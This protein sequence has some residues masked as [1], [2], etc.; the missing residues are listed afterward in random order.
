MRRS[1]LLGA[2][3][4]TLLLALMM[5]GAWRSFFT[6][7]TV[8]MEESLRPPV[9][10]TLTLWVTGQDSGDRRLLST[11]LSLYEKSRPGLRIYLRAADASELYADSAVLPD[12][13]FYSQGDILRPEDCL[14]PLNLPAAQICES[15]S[16]GKSRGVLYGAPLWYAPTLLSLPSQWLMPQDSNE[17]FGGESY[18]G[19]STPPPRDES[20]SLRAE[21]LPWEQ[22]LA[23]EQLYI[24][25][26][27]SMLQLMHFCP[28]ARRKELA[29][30]AAGGLAEVPCEGIA[31]VLSCP[32]YLSAARKE[33]LLAIP[34]TPGVSDRVRFFSLCREND[35]VMGLLS[36]LNSP[37][38]LAEMH[39]AGFLP[40]LT[41]EPPADSLLARCIDTNPGTVFFPNAFAHTAEELNALC[42]DAF[43]RC[44]DPVA[45]LLRL[46]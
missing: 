6:G 26:G 40:V 20:D 32:E 5:P 36:F 11:L 16:A 10:R 17:S 22:I 24:R 38:C 2:L 33:S 28:E 19:K 3:L 25:P 42:L 27:V 37:Q 43:R 18:F 4:A 46:R 30:L 1:G 21:S 44:D 35:D 12:G 45:A 8:R 23:P 13:I 31:R 34:L 39:K 14:L 41:A 15:F 9:M 7:D 29:A